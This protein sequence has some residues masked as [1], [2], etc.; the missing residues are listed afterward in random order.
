MATIIQEQYR[1]APQ[2]DPFVRQLIGAQQ[3]AE[4]NEKQR[5]FAAAQL[6][7]ELKARADE[8]T[9][10]RLF[11]KE[12]VGIEHQYKLDQLQEEYDQRRTLLNIED[13]RK[14]REL[15]RQALIGKQMSELFTR[16]PT[17]QQPQGVPG[18]SGTG[19]QGTPL[20][21]GVRE[22]AVGG[23][24]QQPQYKPGTGFE[25]AF[26]AT[27]DVGDA[28][29]FEQNLVSQIER[30]RAD[31]ALDNL[32]DTIAGSGQPGASIYAQGLRVPGDTGE[33]R[34]LAE[35]ASKAVKPED[36]KTF[37]RVISSQAGLNRIK[38]NLADP[39]ALDDLDIS[40]GARVEFRRN[41]DGKFEVVSFPNM[42]SKS[43]TVNVGT[44][45][46]GN[47]V[48]KGF[49][50]AF[51]SGPAASNALQKLAQVEN[52][53]VQGVQTGA[54]QNIVTP[55]Q[56]L[57][58]DAG[59]DVTKVANRIGVNIGNLSEKEEA[60][61]LSKELALE[62][63]DRLPGSL[64]FNEIKFAQGTVTDIGKSE[65]ANMI[66]VA[67]MQTAASA[68]ARR[69][70]QLLEGVAGVEPKDYGDVYVQIQREAIQSDPGEA[71]ERTKENLAN[72]IRKMQERGTFQ[73]LSKENRE[74]LAK[75]LER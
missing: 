21:P 59:I 70:Q 5:E 34:Q 14:A 10:R 47:A 65:A 24:P 51:E 36:G 66:A 25:L 37:E 41:Q 26:G 33:R 49:E 13:A 73:N 42:G 15:E 40:K 69:Y 17:R 72:M 11:E 19:A 23:Q 7:K 18:V 63:V 55:L 52:L 67:A 35:S 27:G 20:R 44:S 8:A 62:V 53:L 39:T 71:V 38:K 64:A 2:S 57:A 61:R 29:K 74:A 3:Q 31:E 6:E 30:A 32:A 16:G 48:E 56:A 12:L 28:L 58:S 46:A 43:T 45:V 9:T 4:Q 50:R 60:D 75:F 22:Q 68:A 1:P 54:L